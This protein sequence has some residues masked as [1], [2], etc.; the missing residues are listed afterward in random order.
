MNFIAN[1]QTDVYMVPALC[2]SSYSIQITENINL[3]NPM[4]HFY[5][6]WKRQKTKGTRMEHW[7]KMC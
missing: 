4:F 1:Q 6:R 7:A 2:K 5:T 3:L